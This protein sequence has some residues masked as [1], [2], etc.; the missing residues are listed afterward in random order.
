MNRYELIEAITKLL[1]RTEYRLLVVI[2][3]MLK[4]EENN[5]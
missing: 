5:G 2:Y 4:S 1:D 3:S